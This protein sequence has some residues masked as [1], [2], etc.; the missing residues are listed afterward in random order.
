[1]RAFIELGLDLVARPAR[2]PTVLRAR[3]FRERIAALDHEALHDAVKSSPV[4]ESLVGEGFEVL[5]GFGRN[6]GPEFHDH[7]ARGRFDDSNF[8]HFEKGWVEIGL[9]DGIGGNDLDADD[10]LAFIGPIRRVRGRGGNFLEH[11]V[12]IDQLAKRGVLMIEE[13]GVTVADEKLAA[14]GIRIGGA[15]H[16]ENAANVRAVIELRLDRV[17]GSTGAPAVLG[18]RVLRERIATLDHETLDYPMK[19]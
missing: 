7:F 15:R 19:T 1:M 16:G 8:A 6:V 14:G 5:D 2:A 9:L 18:G 4:V 11:I 12:T 17:T 13:T 10:A 3:V